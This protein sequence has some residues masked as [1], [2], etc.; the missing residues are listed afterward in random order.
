MIETAIGSHQGPKGTER[1]DDLWKGVFTHPRN[2]GHFPKWI[3]P[4]I[5]FL[6]SEKRQLVTRRKQ[7]I[8]EINQGRGWDEL[9]RIGRYGD[10]PNRWRVHQRSLGKAELERNFGA[11]RLSE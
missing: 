10:D 4:H 8:A 11:G 1:G 2:G 5:V 3:H 9:I 7:P 6:P